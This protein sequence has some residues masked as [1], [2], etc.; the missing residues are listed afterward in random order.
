M[1]WHD[2]RHFYASACASAGIPIE[3]VAKY[4]GHAD[5]DTMYEH[6]LHLFSDGHTG[7]VARLAAVAS[8]SVA[9]SRRSAVRLARH[10]GSQSAWLCL[11]VDIVA[12]RRVQGGNCGPNQDVCRRCPE[13]AGLPREAD[14]V[15]RSTED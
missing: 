6:Y 10:W 7:D 3:R 12:A 9:P 14:R 2:L 4:M 5:I 11:L 13:A 15:G 8:R 1:R